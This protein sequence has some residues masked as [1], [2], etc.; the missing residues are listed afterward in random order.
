MKKHIFFI[1]LLF[2]GSLA[3]AQ[4]SSV[5]NHLKTLSSDEMQGRG[6]GSEGGEK[7]QDYISAQFEQLGLNPAFDNTYKQPFKYKGKTGNNIVAIV[8]GE[9]ENVIVVTAHFD[10]LGVKDSKIYNGADDNASGTAALFSIGEYFKNNKPTH[11]LVLAAVDAEEVGSGGAE[12]LLKNFPYP[13]ENIVMN[14][15]LD[16][17]AHNDKNELYAVGT[18]HYPQLKQPLSKVDSEINILFGHDSPKDDDDWTYASDHRVFHRKKI[19]FIYF[20]VEDHKDYHQPS[21][22]FENINKEFYLNAV[23]LIIQAIEA[24]DSSSAL[25]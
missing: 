10:H 20:G 12:Y 9:T 15:N 24:Y 25:R 19:P 21:D 5:L 17:I 14:V 23:N 8:P 22:T 2:A 18:Y 4:E 11:T 1:L 13:K 16:M 7:A 3:S 6:Y